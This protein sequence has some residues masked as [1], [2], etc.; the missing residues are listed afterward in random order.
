MLSTIGA[1]TVEDA[2]G[3]FDDD[4]PGETWT[5][6]ARR[7]LDCRRHTGLRAIFFACDLRQ[8]GSADPGERRPGL[9]LGER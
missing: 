7:L 1:A 6:R 3:T 4:T 2:P 9:G 8:R 5:R